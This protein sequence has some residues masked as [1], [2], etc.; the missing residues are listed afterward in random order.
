M[1]NEERKWCVYKHMSPSGKIYI[2][3][4][5]QEPPEK[6]WVNGCGYRNNQYFW[7]AIQ[8]YGWNN[9]EHEI[10]F[11]NLSKED[12]ANKEKE[13]ISFYNSNNSLY[14]YNLSSGGEGGAEGVIISEEE[15]KRR[16]EHAKTYV[17]ENNP[18]YGNHKLAGENNPF[19]NKEHS[20][21]MR[22]LLSDLAKD[23]WK[24]EKY[25]QHM[26]D[27]HKN[28]NVGAENPRA[29]ATLQYDMEENFIKEWECAKIAAIVLGICYSGITQC[30][31][32]RRKSAGGFI[33]RYKEDESD[34]EN[35]RVN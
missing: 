21:E 19:F 4:T 35:K 33:W 14:G 18:N 12:A 25:K 34:K 20:E 2:G 7:R 27:V 17:G 30:C 10:L 15:R 22:Q 31:S 23:R 1:S 3:I 26:I 11:V 6:R 24:N 29:K 16:S 8:K 28:Q 13:L 5:C 32:G 9:F